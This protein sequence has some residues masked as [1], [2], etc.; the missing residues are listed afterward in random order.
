MMH[1]STHVSKYT[2]VLTYKHIYIHTQDD[3]HMQ[4][5]AYGNSHTHIGTYPKSLT[6]T[7]INICIHVYTYTFFMTCI[8]THMFI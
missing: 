2:C 3:V 5:N 6:D 1:K 8:R 4:I 7:C